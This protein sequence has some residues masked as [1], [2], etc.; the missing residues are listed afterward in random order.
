[1]IKLPREIDTD[2]VEAKSSDGILTIV[3]PKAEAAKP[4]QISVRVS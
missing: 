2:K 4:K 1:M 3:L